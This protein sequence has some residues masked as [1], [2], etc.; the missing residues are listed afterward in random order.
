MSFKLLVS[1]M[2][3]SIALVSCNRPGGP[4]EGIIYYDVSFPFLEE[5]V[6]VNVFPEQL[7]VTFKDNE[8]RGTLKSLGGIVTTEFIADNE[9]QLLIQVLKSFQE[10]SFCQMSRTEVESQL[11]IMPKFSYE[12]TDEK[13]VV[14]GYPCKVTI[15]KFTTDSMPP[16]RLLHTDTFNLEHPNWFTQFHEIEDVLLG[17]EI[18]HFGMRMKLRATKIE[19]IEIDAS[20][21]LVDP[22][23]K[24]ISPKEMDGLFTDMMSEFTTQEP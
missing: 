8:V 21:F 6:L 5:S 18:E 24:N 14:A 19:N 22:D 15:A 4:D 16:I 10:K 23:Y 11:A 17:Y 13:E 2:A 9:E 20:E 7:I 3:L 1:T 12:Q